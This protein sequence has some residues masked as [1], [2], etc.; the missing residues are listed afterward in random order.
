MLTVKVPSDVCG[1][2]RSACRRSGR[3][4]TGGMLFG[5]HTG[6]EEF[7]ILEATIAGKGSESR[8]IRGL[9]PGLWRLERFF[10]RTNRDYSRF[11]YLGEWH[12]HPSFP[13]VPS[14]P[15]DS[16]MYEIVNDPQTGARF[17]ILLL[18]TWPQDAL[19]AK[20]FLYIPGERRKEV[21]VLVE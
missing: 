14:W 19:R 9:L 18:V 11:N 17:V 6:D 15:D 1:T 20:G 10:R 3:L 16:S 13:L 12:S 2:L 8:F 21:R 4:E 7:R 5:E